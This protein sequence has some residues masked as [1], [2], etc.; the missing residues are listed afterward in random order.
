MKIFIFDPITLINIEVKCSTSL[1]FDVLNSNTT[2]PLRRNIQGELKLFSESKA[3]YQIIT[4]LALSSHQRAYLVVYLHN[5]KQLYCELIEFDNDAQGKWKRWLTV[6]LHKW[7]NLCLVPLTTFKNSAILPDNINQI[8]TLEEMVD[9]EYE[10]SRY[11][12]AHLFKMANL[13][14]GENAWDEGVL[15]PLHIFT[16]AI[17]Y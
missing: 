10:G 4:G 16:E 1:N 5:S 3:Y 12:H 2:F 13:Y 11:V 9:T 8:C 6:L 17:I 14:L 7:C 15:D